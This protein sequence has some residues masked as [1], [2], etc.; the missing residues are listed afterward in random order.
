[1]KRYLSSC[2]SLLLAVAVL[3]GAISPYTL[4]AADEKPA[5]KPAEKSSSKKAD[6]KPAPTADT[7]TDPEPTAPETKAA[8]TKPVDAQPVPVPAAAAPETAVPLVPRVVS[9]A[10]AG[11]LS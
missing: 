9:V 3:S 10:V 8:D 4:R 11:A 1:M 2:L 7:E 6:K 5:E